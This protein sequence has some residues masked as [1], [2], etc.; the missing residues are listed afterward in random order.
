MIENREKQKVSL[1]ELIQTETKANYDEL[2]SGQV[3]T[4]LSRSN[5]VELI[6]QRTIDFK[7]EA[8]STFILDD[9]ED[10]DQQ[11]FS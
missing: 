10:F 3:S 1:V 5:S 9:H 2:E 4:K 7:K 11:Y 8:V 6:K